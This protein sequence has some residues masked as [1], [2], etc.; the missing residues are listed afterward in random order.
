M[1]AAQKREMLM[2]LPKRRGVDMRISCW[3]AS[4]P[5]ISRIFLWALSNDPGGSVLKKTRAHALRLRWCRQYEGM[6]SCQHI[7]SV[8]YH[9]LGG[10]YFT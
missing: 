9:M 2:V 7:V 5:L 4:Q 3:R 10:G 8:S 6:V 1:S